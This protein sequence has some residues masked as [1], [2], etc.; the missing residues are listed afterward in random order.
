M[1]KLWQT[2]NI[3]MYLV[4][5]SVAWLVM[6]PVAGQSVNFSYSAAVVVITLSFW[7]SGMIPPFLAS[8]I[9][10]A[11]AS[12]FKLIDPNI[13]FSGFSSAA[14]WLIISG[15]IIG[16]AISKTGLS[17]RLVSFIAPFLIRSYSVLV[18]GLVVSAILLGF[19]MPSSVG[20]AV[21]MIPIGMALAEQVGLK[22]GSKGRVGIA[23]ALAISCNMPS[24]AVLPANIPNMILAGASE[25][26]F[27]VTFGYLDY[28]LLHFPVLGLVKSLLL[29]F[30]V[31]KTFPADL[32]PSKA[33]DKVNIDKKFNVGQQKKLGV[34]LGLTL[35]FWMSDSI[36]GI[37]PAWIGLV[38][39]ILLLIPKYGIVE[40]KTFSSSVDFGVVVFV[41]GALGL[42]ALV[43]HSGIGSY[44]GQEFSNLLPG[45]DSGHFLNFM[46]LNLIS[47]V[48]GLI[49][50]I[51][52]VP[53]VL[54][55]MAADLAHSTGFSLK[56]VLMTQVV[57]FSTVIFP[58]QVA[59]LI[60]AMQLANERLSDLFKIL[61][62]L[63]VI[64][65]VFLM[66][67]DYLWWCLL[68]WF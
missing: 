51:P 7:S 55:P 65:I 19:I 17:D 62:P 27:G 33:L 1:N 40:P 20:R 54:T 52:G 50:T 30:I 16:N 42:G 15:F 9:F 35:L 5:F 13:L 4:V 32:E 66:P 10:F 23:V 68:G 37:N 14:V 22:H 56:A 44:V 25:T 57:G 64:T 29:I 36:H 41:A 61:L 24:F 60:L 53:T 12:I 8:L 34:L 38:T 67:L 48:T 31:I 28:L 26:I 21:V 45:A 58:Y 3:A 46:V 18:A 63:S 43:N 49:A 59:P 47:T 11:L 39:A 2:K 6:F